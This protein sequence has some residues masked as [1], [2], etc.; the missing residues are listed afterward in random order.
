MAFVITIV[1]VAVLLLTYASFTIDA[2]ITV[3]PI[4]N[5][6]PDIPDILTTLGLDDDNTTGL[7]YSLD[8]EILTIPAVQAYDTLRSLKTT[9]ASTFNTVTLCDSLVD[10][11]Q[12]DET[13]DVIVA[14]PAIPTTN[15]SPDTVSTDGLDDEYVLVRIYSESRSVVVTIVT[16]ASKHTRS[17]ISSKFTSTLNLVSIAIRR[18]LPAAS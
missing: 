18:L 3:S 1:C 6:I 10:A 7:P 17:G 13:V 14:L 5:T 12:F 2:V 4:L 9:G 11:T 16:G 8:A 15:L